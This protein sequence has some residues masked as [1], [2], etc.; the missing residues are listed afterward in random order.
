M[1]RRVILST[2]CDT[3]VSEQNAVFAPSGR[4]TRRQLITVGGGAVMA[5]LAG[6]S[7]S[8][9]TPTPRPEEATVT[10]QIRNRDD[11]PRAFEVTV[12]QGESVTDSFSGVLPAD[13]SQPVEMVATFRATEKQH[14]FTIATERGQQG[15]TWDPTEC[16]DFFVDAFVEDGSPGFE[17]ACRST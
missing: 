12:N 9:E 1:S 2:W 15:R 4:P 14:D 6:C 16:G 17:T 10:V 11:Q 8:S 13:E 3:L 7:S 5:A